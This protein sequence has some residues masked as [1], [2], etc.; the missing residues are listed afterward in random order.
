[1]ERTLVKFFAE[2]CQSKGLVEMQLNVAAQSL[3]HVGLAIA[4]H[5][6][7][8]AAQ[9][10]AIAGL[11]GLVGPRKEFDILPTRATCGAGGAAIDPSTRYR[12]HD[13]PVVSAVASDDGIPA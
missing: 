8:T 1:M 10:G 13:Q 6:L 7:R 3:H 5:G 2:S 11:F 9:A 4:D 12:K